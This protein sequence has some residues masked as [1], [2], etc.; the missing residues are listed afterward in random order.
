MASRSAPGEGANTMCD[1]QRGIVLRS[2]SDSPI[3][4]ML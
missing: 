4:A 3:V 2:R 1:K